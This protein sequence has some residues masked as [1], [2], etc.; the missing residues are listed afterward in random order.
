MIQITIFY[1]CTATFFLWIFTSFYLCSLSFLLICVDPCIFINVGLSQL[2]LG[3]L[4]ISKCC[5]RGYRALTQMSQWVEVEGVCVCAY[6]MRA[7]TC[8]CLCAHAACMHVSFKLR[9][10]FLPLSA[11]LEK[12]HLISGRDLLSLPWFFHLWSFFY[13]CVFLTNS[14][15]S[16]VTFVFCLA[17]W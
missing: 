6:H 15:P 17:P 12:I 5:S 4:N 9:H 11:S 13:V 3:S 16:D 2:H 7:C 1:N 10:V 14:F 8:A